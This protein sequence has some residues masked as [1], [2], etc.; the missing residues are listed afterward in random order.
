MTDRILINKLEFY[1]TNVCNLTCSNCNRYNNYKFSGHWRWADAEPVLAQWAK[2]IQIRQLVILGGEPL[3]NP[4]IIQWI[5][6]LS[7]LWPKSDG[8][9]GVQILTNGT[10]LDLIPGLYESLLDGAWIGVSMHSLEHQ[11]RLFSKIRNFL[12]HPIQET[13]GTNDKISSFRHFVDVNKKNIYVWNNSVFGTSNI[14]QQANDTFGLYNS[15]PEVAHENCSFR[16]YK[17]YHMIHGKIYKCG[18]VALMSEFDEQYPFDISEEDRALLHAPNR[19]LAVDEFDQRGPEFL[20]NI[21]RVIPQCKFCPESYE[22]QP[23][24]FTTLKPNKI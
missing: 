4:D 22:Y 11:E 10:R 19:G 3:L 15:N 8:P 13:S 23:I 21:D 7:R 6:G 14:I 20:S 1:I 16:R 17:N 18:P 2:K 9:K 24:T 5:T 12:K